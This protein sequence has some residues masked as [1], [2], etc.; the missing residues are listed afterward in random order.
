MTL[1]RI[2][3]VD[4]H[5]VV[6]EGLSALL[7]REPDMSVVAEAGDGQQAVQM[8]RIHRPAVTLMDLRLPKLGGIEATAAIRSRFPEARVIILTS[9]DGEEDIYRALESGARAYLLKSV[10]R[11]ELLST[12]R[13][14]AA[15]G[16]RIPPFVAERLAQRIQKSTLTGRELD[17]LQ[18][19]VPGQHHGALLVLW[20]V[21]LQQLG[22]VRGHLHD[23]RHA[24]ALR[25]L[26]GGPGAPGVCPRVRPYLPVDGHPL[27][28]P[29]PGPSDRDGLPHLLR[30]LTLGSTSGPS[31]GPEPLHP[32]W[33]LG[34]GAGGGGRTRTSCDGRF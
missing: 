14:V 7:N 21:L 22:R 23:L 3:V 2:L 1:I 16:C 12:V 26:V 19:P 11:E 9:F 20:V 17:V 27:R 32:P 15:G 4:D 8:H 25:D 30:P 18:G 5:L 10:S 34:G 28:Q 13:T 29:E 24:V 33:Q 31:S 6:R